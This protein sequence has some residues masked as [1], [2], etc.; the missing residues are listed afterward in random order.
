MKTRNPIAA[1]LRN[2]SLRPQ[3]VLPKKGKRPY[4][5]NNSIREK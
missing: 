2:P 3:V 1:A 5:R 4:K